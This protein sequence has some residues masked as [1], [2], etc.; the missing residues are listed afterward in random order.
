[1]G[2]SLP[3]VETYEFSENV[4]GEFQKKPAIFSL[5]VS[6]VYCIMSFTKVRKKKVLKT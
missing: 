1:M 6:M 2:R 4:H 5:K 3:M